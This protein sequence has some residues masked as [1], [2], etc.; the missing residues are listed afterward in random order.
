M[1]SPEFDDG[2]LLKK[3]AVLTASCSPLTAGNDVVSYL[4]FGPALLVAGGLVGGT[5]VVTGLLT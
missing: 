1:F 4:L 5:A 3:A 2:M